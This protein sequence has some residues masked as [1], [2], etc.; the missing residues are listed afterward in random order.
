MSE[1]TPKELEAFEKFC[2]DY[3]RE[4]DYP[5]ISPKDCSLAFTAGLACADRLREEKAQPAVQTYKQEDYKCGYCGTSNRVSVQQPAGRELSEAEKKELNEAL[6]LVQGAVYTAR[7]EQ[8]REELLIVVSRLLGERE[9][10]ARGLALEEAA[11]RIELGKQGHG[12]TGTGAYVE[13]LLDYDLAAE[14]IR[15]L[16]PDAAKAL[17]EHDQEIAMRILNAVCDVLK[18]KIPPMAIEPCVDEVCEILA[19]HSDLAIAQ[20]TKTLREALE[21]MLTWKDGK[22]GENQDWRTIAK[23]ALA[24]CQQA[25]LTEE[26]EMGATQQASTQNQNDPF[27]WRDGLPYCKKHGTRLL[28]R[29]GTSVGGAMY[30][31]ECAAVGP[32]YHYWYEHMRT[33]EQG[34]EDGLR[35]MLECACKICDEHAETLQDHDKN[36]TQ[37]KLDASVMTSEGIKESIRRAALERF[38]VKEEK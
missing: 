15:A 13:Q 24:A 29:L 27:E 4:H 16:D 25:A 8:R 20:A 5:I 33:Y 26:D 3:R 14:A 28:G 6:D 7:E 34:R 1:L 31:L 9:S 12:G 19:A 30:C 11:Q 36:A 38:G 2:T 32:G 22:I 35:E 17:R 21:K 18:G 37:R 23:E 10:L